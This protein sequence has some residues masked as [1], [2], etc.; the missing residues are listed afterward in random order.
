MT[1]KLI[2][3]VFVERP[4][5]SDTINGKFLAPAVVPTATVAWNV[6][7]L[8]LPLKDCVADPPMAVKLAVTVM[9]LLAGLVPGVTA[10]VKVVFSPGKTEVGLADPLPDGLV[11]VGYCRRCRKP[12]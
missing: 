8:P 11:E 6:K 3:P 1:V 4:S 2:E 10:T 5:E 12:D 9:P 7:V